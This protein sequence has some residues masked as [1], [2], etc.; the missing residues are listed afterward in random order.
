MSCGGQMQ[1]ISWHKQFIAVF[2]FLL[3]HCLA[4]AADQKVTFTGYGA[5]G[6]KVYDVRFSQ[7]TYYEGKLQAEIDLQKGIEA[8]LDL[9]GN[10]ADNAV[11]FR[12]FSVKFDLFDKLN[13]KIG[14][15][16]K[17][18]V[19][20]YILNREELYTVE[21][22]LAY[23]NAEILGYG[24]RSVSVMAYYKYKE[25]SPEFPFS[26]Y[27]SLYKNN[28]LTSGLVARGEY[29]YHSW[30]FAFSY[31]SQSRGG[32]VDDSFHGMALE[33]AFEKNKYYA[34]INL[35]YVQDPIVSHQKRIQSDQQAGLVYGIGATVIAAKTFK[36]DKRVVHSIEPALTLSRFIPDSDYFDAHINQAMIGCNIYFTKDVRLRLNGDL[37][38]TKNRFSDYSDDE[39]GYIV[40]L[41]V[42][43]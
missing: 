21:R 6:L 19:Y 13:L 28:S 27:L 31:M 24:G 29:H 14:N 8:Q 39:S 33:A 37:R 15:I 2:I 3:I 25:K 9:R 1:I 10:S 26:Y 12:E 41:E 23:Q 34:N 20:E 11:N 22:S 17:P 32:W 4:Q 30:A 38:L 18:F 35:M 16:K 7:Q 40:E 5:T 36:I 43:F 42:K